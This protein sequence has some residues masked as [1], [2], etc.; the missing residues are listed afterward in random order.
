MKTNTRTPL[1]LVTLLIAILN[2]GF[3]PYVVAETLAPPQVGIQ[4]SSEKLRLKIQQDKSFILK[5]TEVNAFVQQNIYPYV[6]FN[7]M[8]AL[9]LG[10]NWRQASS[11]DRVR[12]TKEFQTLLVRTYSRAFVEFKDWSIRYLPLNMEPGATKVIVNTEVLQPGLQ[13]IGV[14]YRMVLVDDK[15]KAYDI[16]IEGVSLVTNYRSSFN[17]EIARSGSL[18]SVIADLSKRNSEALASNS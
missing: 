16:M 3:A 11:E 17:D 12:F 8:S 18:S 5:F 1:Y 9:V 13:P 7:R 4:E 15:W 14:S 10:Q 2:L 6:D